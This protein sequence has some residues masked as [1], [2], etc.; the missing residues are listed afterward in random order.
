M[1]NWY[2]P[3]ALAIELRVHVITMTN[4]LL[5]QIL[6]ISL[7]I[8]PTDTIKDVIMTENWYLKATFDR[9]FLQDLTSLDEFKIAKVGIICSSKYKHQKYINKFII[10]SDI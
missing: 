6:R 3:F 4:F 1:R 7:L 2:I 5:N 8:I 9:K 10:F